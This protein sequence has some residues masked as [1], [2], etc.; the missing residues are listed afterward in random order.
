MAM[1]YYKL[2]RLSLYETKLE[3]ASQSFWQALN[4]AKTNPGLAAQIEAEI[5]LM[6]DMG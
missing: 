3:E 2:G 1:H 6:Q 5:R 4:L